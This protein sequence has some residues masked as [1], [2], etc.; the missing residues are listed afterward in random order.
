MEWVTAYIEEFQYLAIAFVLF[1]AGLGVP[2][3]EDIPLIYGGIMSGQGKMNVFIHFIV[4]MVFIII[5]DVCLYMIGKRLARSGKSDS[6]TP[7]RLSGLLTEERKQKVTSYFDRYGSWTVFFGRF[8]AGI[9]GGVFLTAGMTGFPLRRFIL[10]DGL[11]ALIS[12]PV[13]IGLG[14]WFGH[15]Y[16]VILEQLKEHQ[17]TV[18]IVIIGLGLGYWLYRRS[19]SKKTT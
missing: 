10:L 14:Y 3:P 15:E 2:I 8:V 11:A 5:G 6:E 19:T 16:D 17:L 7:S 9:R 13:W 1:I 4:S 18:L 12:V